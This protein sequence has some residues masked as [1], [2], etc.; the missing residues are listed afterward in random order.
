MRN[1]PGPAI[2]HSEA[3]LDICVGNTL[4]VSFGVHLEVPVRILLEVPVDGS[5]DVAIVVIFR[6]FL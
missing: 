3:Y 2:V 4:E 6:E 1:F 5:P